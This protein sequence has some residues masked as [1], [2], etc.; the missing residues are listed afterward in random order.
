MVTAIIVTYNRRQFLAEAI[1]SVLAQTFLL[2][3]S[4]LGAADYR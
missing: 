1:D 4:G 2:K 3:P